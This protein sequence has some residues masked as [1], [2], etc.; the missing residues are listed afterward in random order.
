M[1][2]PIFFMPKIVKN[3]EFPF[4]YWKW[5]NILGIHVSSLPLQPKKCLILG[6]FLMKN[7]VKFLGIPM[8]SLGGV[9]LISGKAHLINPLF[10]EMAANC[11]L[12]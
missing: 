4:L 6:D 8:Y 3:W 7:V 11:V 5:L 1:G 9:H 2:I 10:I 12:R